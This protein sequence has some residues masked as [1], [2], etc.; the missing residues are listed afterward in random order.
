MNV[1]DRLHDISQISGFSEDIVR[2]VL[3]AEAQS[4]AKSLR[5]GEKVALIGR[6][7]IAPCIGTRL[8]AEE[9]RVANHIKLK[10]TIAKSLLNRVSGLE[11]FED[12]DEPV[13]MSIPG[14]VTD[15]I[16]D[17]Q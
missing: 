2:K 12:S 1:Q 13:L 15:Q 11:D 3:D 17:L 5:R 14:M 6:C 8:I 4:A 9:A 16:E 7:T 10:A